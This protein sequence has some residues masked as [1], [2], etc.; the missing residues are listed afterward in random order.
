MTSVKED[1]TSHELPRLNKAIQNRICVHKRQ[2]WR[3]FVE[4]MDQKTD[5]TKL[6]R[7]IKGIDGRAKREVHPGDNRRKHILTHTDK[8]VGGSIINYAAPVWST[9]IRDTN[10]RNIQYTQSEALRISTGCHKMSSIDHLHV[11]AEMMKVSEHSQLLSA[12]YLDR[13]LE[14]EN[15]CHSI[16]TRETP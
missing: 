10:Y 12:Q 1:P 4:N 3:D 9:N 7:T 2:K 14:P 5:L 16:T 13:C 6:W 8:A 11:E 15:V